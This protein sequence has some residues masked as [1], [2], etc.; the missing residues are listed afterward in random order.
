MDG[1][2]KIIT[3]RERRRRWSVQDKLRIVAELAE[4]GARVCDVAARHGVCE[5]PWRRQLREGV[6]VE[7]QAPTF[8]PIRMLETLSLCQATSGNQPQA[9]SDTHTLELQVRQISSTSRVV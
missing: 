7:P 5:S 9:T 3:K 8:L 1:V 4:P 2:M 6:L